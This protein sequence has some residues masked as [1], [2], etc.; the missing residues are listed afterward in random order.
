[1]SRLGDPRAVARGYNEVTRDLYQTRRDLPAFVLVSR[2]GIEY[3][4]IKATEADRT[5]PSAANELRGAAKTLAYNL[6]ANTW[7]GWNEAGIRIRPEDLEAGME[8]ARLNL[9]LALELQ[10]GAEPLF[11]AYWIIGALELA[12]GRH[13]EAIASYEQARKLANQESLRGYALLAGGSIA[14]AKIAGKVDVAAGER[15]F[16]QAKTALTT[17]NL[18]DGKF[19]ADQLDVAYQVFV[20][21]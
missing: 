15:E 7:P 8:A 1:M 11:N 14:I 18:S 10:R 21:K 6:A 3:L 17:G 4:L 12:Q 2:Q 20:R 9:R 5:D 19:L 13:N 16:V